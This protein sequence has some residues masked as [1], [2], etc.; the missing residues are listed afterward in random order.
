MDEFE[1]AALL[2][3]I[4]RRR[5]AIMVAGVVAFGVLYIFV[6][7][8]AV[9]IA[10]GLVIVGVGAAYAIWNPRGNR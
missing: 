7:A 10:S 2:E 6:G 1:K 5:N 9:Y 3:A 4:Q 8:T